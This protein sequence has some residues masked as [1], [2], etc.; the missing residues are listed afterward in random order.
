MPGMIDALPTNSYDYVSLYSLLVDCVL[1]SRIVHFSYRFNFHLFVW[2]H[3][4][5]IQS[6]G[7]VGGAVQ[8]VV[9]GVVGGVVLI[10]LPRQELLMSEYQ[11]LAAAAVTTVGQGMAGPLG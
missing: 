5:I 10:V 8:G 3:F 11:L 4:R 2:H 7:V 1:T 9:V 6:G